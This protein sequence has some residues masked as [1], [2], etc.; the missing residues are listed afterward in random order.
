MQFTDGG[1]HAGGRPAGP[2]AG[3]VIDQDHGPA[4]APCFPG[5]A[6]A[7]DSATDHGDVRV[8][9]TSLL[10]VAL[11][12]PVG[13]TMCFLPYAGTSRIRSSGRL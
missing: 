8:R 4:G 7:N 3:R 1:E 5:D 6:V 10:A 9:R 11:Q 2:G 12:A 13:G